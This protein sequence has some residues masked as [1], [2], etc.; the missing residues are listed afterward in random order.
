[1]RVTERINEIKERVEARARYVG[2]QWDNA[3]Q[4]YHAFD[5]V[6]GIAEGAEE[7]GAEGPAHQEG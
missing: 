7:H 4:L 2:E 1:M 6:N 5:L 3:K